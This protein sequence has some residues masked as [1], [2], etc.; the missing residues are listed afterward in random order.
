MKQIP[1]AGDLITADIPQADPPTSGS[2]AE[3]TNI[4]G[5]ITAIIPPIRSQ[6]TIMLR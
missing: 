3:P 4:P 1:A 2:P 6:E 5:K